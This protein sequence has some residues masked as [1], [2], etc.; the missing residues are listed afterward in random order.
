[1]GQYCLIADKTGHANTYFEYKR[2]LKD[3]HKDVISCQAQAST[4]DE[5]LE[6]LRKALVHTMRLGDTLVIY[7]DQT[8]PDFK[9]QFTSEETFPTEQIFEY[10]HWREQ[11]N[12]MKL[13]REDE[14]RDFEGNKNC[15][16]MQ[17]T[18]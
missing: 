1:M 10:D 9:T 7:V 2:H 11:A 13:V 3:F 14:N 5:A 16:Q 4:E 17:D 18:F 15:F 6:V 8:R 12:Y